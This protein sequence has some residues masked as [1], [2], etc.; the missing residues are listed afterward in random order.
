M[1]TSNNEHQAIILHSKGITIGI[2][3]VCQPFYCELSWF[4]VG[5]ALGTNES[6][7]DAESFLTVDCGH[8][9]L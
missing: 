4:S 2:M 8:L 9:V 7:I 1:T 6:C 5:V 3:S